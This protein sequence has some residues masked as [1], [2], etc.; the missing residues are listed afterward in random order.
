MTIYE[1][2][3]SELSEIK[4][5]S[6]N[7][8][9]SYG[10]IHGDCSPDNLIKLQHDVS[11]LDFDSIKIDFQ[12]FDLTDLLLKY[13]NEPK[14]NEELNFIQ[15]YIKITGF[16]KSN[17]LMYLYNIL[18][19]ISCYRGLLMALSTEYYCFEKQKFSPEVMG[20]FFLKKVLLLANNVKY[21]LR[22]LRKCQEKLQEHTGEF[23]ATLKA[24]T[25]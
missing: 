25:N 23:T 2:L 10:F 17:E 24:T 4:L 3:I 14:Q 21:R 6:Q 19:V 16:Y 20:T 5:Q 8:Y 13:S 15:E 11:F 22:E 12:L 18:N 1:N 9:L 7:Q